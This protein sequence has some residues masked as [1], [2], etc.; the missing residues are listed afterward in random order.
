MDGGSPRAITPENVSFN[1]LDPVAISPDGESVAVSGLDG[2]IVLYPLDDGAPRGVPKLADG[3]APLRWCPGNS[4]LV[5]QPGNV[6]IK[7]L[8]VDIE[9]GEQALWRELAPA[10]RTGL[11]FIVGTRVGA[12]CQSSGYSVGYA[13]SELWIASGLR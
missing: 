11:T 5:Y 9:T 1:N 2:K 12:D 6:P 13:P 3:F 8:Q 7:I 10:Y 4:L